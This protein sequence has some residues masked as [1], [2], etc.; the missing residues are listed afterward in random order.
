MVSVVDWW[1]ELH[2]VGMERGKRRALRVW[3]RREGEI[4]DTTFS[5]GQACRHRVGDEKLKLFS[6][7]P[8]EK[9]PAWVFHEGYK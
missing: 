6:H 4:F 8:Y 7:H 3:F 9:R 5:R 1:L 2:V